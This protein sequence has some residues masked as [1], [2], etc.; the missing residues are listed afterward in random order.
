[1]R[2]TP[3]ELD[4]MMLHYAGTLAKSRKDKGIKLSSLHLLQIL[5]IVE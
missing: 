1:M 3:R 5:L 2:L 4:K